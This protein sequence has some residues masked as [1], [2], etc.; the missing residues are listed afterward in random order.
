M[1]AS[2]PSEFYLISLN[3]KELS[4]NAVRF[5]NVTQME[6][7]LYDIIEVLGPSRHP[8]Q[9]QSYFKLVL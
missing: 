8:N 5:K 3:Y 9:S 6:K 7:R 2:M 1:H 4:L